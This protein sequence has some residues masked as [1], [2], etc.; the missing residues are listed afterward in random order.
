MFELNLKRHRG[1]YTAIAA[2]AVAELFVLP[3]AR[4]LAL[5]C[6]INVFFL[7]YLLM[8]LPVATSR[9]TADYLRRHAD[10]ED[11]PA[12]ALFAIMFLAA[13]LSA[14]SLLLVMIGGS[15]GAGLRLG[16]STSGVFL[17]WFAV[18]TMM[19]M[20]YAYEFYG[21]PAAGRHT[22]RR[23]GTVGGLDFPGGDD[24]DGTAFLYFSYV[25]GMTAQTS[26]TAISTNAMRRLV[27]I[28]GIFSF[29]FNTVI[30]AAAVNLVIALAR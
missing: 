13:A 8:V 20:H 21:S 25:V 23:D 12:P 3:F 18:H 1:F 19:A 29:F 6:G 27:T 2:T 4:D 14:V 16:L 17:A 5:E 24:P 9:L 11:P 22:A 26:D 30:V 15:V 10:D 7:V 28:H